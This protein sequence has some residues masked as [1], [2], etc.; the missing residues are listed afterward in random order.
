[1]NEPYHNEAQSDPRSSLVLFWMPCS[2]HFRAFSEFVL[3]IETFDILDLVENIRH[4]KFMIIA[5]HLNFFEHVY[6]KNGFR[7]YWIRIF[8]YR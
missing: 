3:M 2:G 5:Y 8:F 7:K 1:M 4:T 6:L